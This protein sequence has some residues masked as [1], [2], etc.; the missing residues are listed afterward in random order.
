MFFTQ[1]LLVSVSYHSLSWEL[2]EEENYFRIN[3]KNDKIK[4]I[5]HTPQAALV[6]SLMSKLSVGSGNIWHIG[7]QDDRKRSRDAKENKTYHISVIY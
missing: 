4:M 6:C 2:N 5:I 7:I 3:A 1:A